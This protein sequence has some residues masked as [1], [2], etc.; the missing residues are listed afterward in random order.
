MAMLTMF[1]TVS[2][3]PVNVLG[4][5]WSLWK[6]TAVVPLLMTYVQKDGMGPYQVSA[7]QMKQ[8]GVESTRNKMVREMMNRC[9]ISWM[10][11]GKDK[12]TTA[13]QLIYVSQ[14][15]RTKWLG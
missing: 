9:C 1:Q 2:C 6:S 3:L 13:H 7:R 4:W 11:S 8:Y 10:C 5:L 15:Q 14:I 12:V